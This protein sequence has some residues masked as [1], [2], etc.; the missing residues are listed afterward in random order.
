[1]REKVVGSIK[2]LSYIQSGGDEKTGAE[3]LLRRNKMIVNGEVQE[4][5][6][7]SGNGVRGIMRR[8]LF[9]DFLNQVGYG[10][11][12]LRLYH[13]FFS[14]GVLESVEEE[15]E[16]NTINLVL[17]K[18]IFANILPVRLFGMAY[19]NQIFEGKLHVGFLLPVCRELQEY[20]PLKDIKHGIY[21]LIDFIFQT[22]RDDLKKEREDDEQAVQMIINYEAF[23]PGTVFYH[24]LI[25][26]GADSIDRSTFARIIKLLKEHGNIGA[27]SSIGLGKVEIN[28]DCSWNDEEYIE[29]I[30]N[31]KEQIVS[32]LEELDV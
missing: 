15:S 2:A 10:L 22:R 17:R 9:S 14:G 27:K 20:I 30:V 8:L 3:V 28:Y 18:R 26:D 23:I 24:E 6:Y 13:A 1:M 25:L 16:T 31:N 12:G 29:F 32:L 5:P 19:G 21:D 4:I 11:K 7:I